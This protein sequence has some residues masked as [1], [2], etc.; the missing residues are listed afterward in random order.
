MNMRVAVV[1][2]LV[3]LAVVPTVFADGVLQLRPGFNLIGLPVDRGFA[4]AESLLSTI[5]FSTP[6]GE[7][8]SMYNWMGSGWQVHPYMTGLNNFVV[9][10]DRGYWI[11]CNGAMGGV[12][13]PIT[14]EKFPETAQLELTT[15]Y[16]LINIP[17]NIGPR[18]AIRASDILTQAS[19]QGVDA[20]IMY[21]W[22]GAG[23]DIAVHQNGQVVGNNF[24]IENGHGYWLFTSNAGTVTI[25]K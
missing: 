11:F 22:N 23:Y 7:C 20:S 21:N 5:D 2:A 8:T 12:S 13:V 1:L 3:V 25:S 17:I 16:N 4:Y 6:E 24:R 18:D 14:G 15:G 10:I 9:E 19:E